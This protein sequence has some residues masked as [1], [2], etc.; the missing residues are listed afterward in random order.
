MDRS[1]HS[2]FKSFVYNFLGCLIRGLID[3]QQTVLPDAY[4]CLEVFCD[5]E[6]HLYPLT[7]HETIIGRDSKKCDI[8]VDDMGVSRQHALIKLTRDGFDIHDIGSTNGILYRGNRVLLRRILDNDS[9]VL[10]THTKITYHAGRLLT[11]KPA[12]TLVDAMRDEVCI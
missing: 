3:L 4:S 11:S 12:L 10:G 8:V 1:S 5:G 7:K 6:Q 9:Y 2:V